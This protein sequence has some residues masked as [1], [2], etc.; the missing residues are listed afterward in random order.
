M[1]QSFGFQGIH[2][3]FWLLMCA[4]ALIGAGYLISTLFRYERRLVPR[5]TGI[6]LLSLRIGVLLLLLFAF[7]QPVM[8][9]TVAASATRTHSDRDRYFREH[10]HAGRTRVAGGKITLG[11]GA[12]DDR[13]QRPRRLARSL[14]RGRRERRRAGMGDRRRRTRS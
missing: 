9:W 4:V 6:V 1:E 13:E 2:Q 7:L 5:R 14:D 12:R 10:E 3:P 8:S 11:S